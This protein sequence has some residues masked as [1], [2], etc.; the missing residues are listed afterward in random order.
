MIENIFQLLNFTVSIYDLLAEFGV[1]IPTRERS[2]KVSC[3]IHGTDSRKSGY[4]Y[5]DTNSFRCYTCN[6]SWD[7]VALCAELHEWWKPGPDGEDV[8]DMG[9]AIGYLKDKYKVEYERPEWEVRFRELKGSAA[10]VQGYKDFPPQDRSQIARLYLWSV[11]QRASQLDR[12][13]RECSWEE[14]RPLLDEIEDLDLAQPSW[15]EDL[16]DWRKR[17]TLVVGGNE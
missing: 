6:K 5:H 3:P 14:V 9:R 13:E 15:K 1:E 10:P 16:N 12:A 17:A 4:I 7:V 8:L 2:C 11:S